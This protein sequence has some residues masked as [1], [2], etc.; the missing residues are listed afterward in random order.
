MSEQC[1]CLNCGSSNMAQGKMHSTGAMNFRPDDAKFLKLKT[2]NVDV[3]AC[4]CLDCG[5][6]FLKAD[7]QKVKELTEKE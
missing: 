6:V 5:S 7:P 1:K 4:L 2:A 3:G